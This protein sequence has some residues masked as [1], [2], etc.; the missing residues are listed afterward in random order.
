[1][2]LIEF[3]SAHYKPKE[4]FY[5]YYKK[6]SF[7]D[8]SDDL[9]TIFSRNTVGSCYQFDQIFLNVLDKHARL[10]RKLLTANHSP[11]I[12][13]PLRK[14]IMRRSYL[15]N[16]HYK[17]KSGKSFKAHKKQK[18]FCSR[19]YKKGKGFSLILIHLLL[20]TI[21]YSGKQNHPFQRREIKNHKLN[22]LKKMTYYKTM[23]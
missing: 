2:H 16:V 13:K 12:S 6:F 3:S 5:R 19:L 14:A 23:I 7:S 4:L 20:L 18:N 22:S 1:M 8:S 17:N 9:K 15:E 21:N 10:K 11:Y